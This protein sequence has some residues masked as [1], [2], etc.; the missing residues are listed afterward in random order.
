MCYNFDYVQMPMG[1]PRLSAAMLP[2]IGTTVSSGA[3]PVPMLVLAATTAAAAARAFAG[4][5]MERDEVIADTDDVIDDVDDVMEV[6]DA[7]SL[8]MSAVRVPLPGTSVALLLR[9]LAVAAAAA[10]CDKCQICVLSWWARPC[11]TQTH[12]HTHTNTT[13]H[14]HTHTHT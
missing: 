11:T 1:M 8:S 6:V 5:S 10:L 4:E 2:I 3:T 7:G 14:T 9:E 12:P 13:H